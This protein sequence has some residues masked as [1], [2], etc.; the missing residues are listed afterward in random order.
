MIHFL[1]QRIS[2]NHIRNKMYQ[3]VID[4]TPGFAN[5]DTFSNIETANMIEY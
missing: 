1:L 5:Y 2:N 4:Q 3:R